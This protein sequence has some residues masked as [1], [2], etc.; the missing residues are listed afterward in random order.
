MHSTFRNLE[1]ASSKYDRSTV[2]SGTKSQS[3]E[4][5]FDAGLPKP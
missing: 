4:Q 1:A 2:N 5:W 3:V